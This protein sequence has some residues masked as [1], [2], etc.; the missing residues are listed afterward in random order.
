[1][2]FF[3]LFKSEIKGSLDLPAFWLKNNALKQA[4]FNQDF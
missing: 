1:M 3:V 2:G 4:I